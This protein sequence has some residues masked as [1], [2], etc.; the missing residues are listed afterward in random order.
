MRRGFCSSLDVDD[1]CE[2]VRLLLPFRDRFGVDQQQVSR[3]K[4]DHGVQRDHAGE[5]GADVQSGDER[6]P[7]DVRDVED[8]EPGG[9]VAEVG[10][11]TQDVRRSVQG[12]TSR[13][14]LSG[15]DELLGEEPHRHLLGTAGVGDVEDHVD[16]AVEPAAT[17]RHMHIATTGEVVAVHAVLAGVPLAEQ[18]RNGRIADV[19]ESDA[20]GG[21]ECRIASPGRRSML[22]AL[23]QQIV[24]D[25]DLPGRGMI[26]ALDRA[27]EA[28]VGGV[29]HVEDRQPRFPEVGRVEV[30]A[31]IDRRPAW[32]A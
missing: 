8:D 21:V 22:H 16:V 23:D 6:R 1:A 27:D 12:D 9:P 10:A 11:I 13:W 17:R 18:P 32:P 28:R 31:R 7:L 24:G 15:G 29:G 20:F 26:G 19:E 2:V 25:L 4:R 3:R 5:R 14:G 30:P